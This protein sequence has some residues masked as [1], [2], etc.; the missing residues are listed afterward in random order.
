MSLRHLSPPFPNS[1]LNNVAKNGLVE[2][3]EG[4]P[5]GV[6]EQFGLMELT[7]DVTD[8]TNGVPLATT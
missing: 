6:K 5:N 7:L 1:P 3:R 2:L 4:G 8:R